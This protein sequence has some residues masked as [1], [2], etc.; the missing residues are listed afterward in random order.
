M[1]TLEH[2]QAATETTGDAA[3]KP[4]AL[5]AEFDNVDAVLAAARRAR[6]AGYNR[7]DV[8]SPF[9]IH[10]IDRVLGTPPTILP[11][12]VL[13][14]GLSG[15]FGALALTNYTMAYF[16]PF[17]ISGK[18]FLSQPAFVPIIFE[19]TILLAGITATV[20][21]LLLNK[22][23]LLANPLLKSERFRRFSSDRMF[24]VIEAKDRRFDVDQTRRFLEDQQPVAVELIHE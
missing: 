1:T 16:Y 7:V 8:H 5:I 3:S 10:G 12:L 15:L 19:C 22:L 18:P 2:Q 23:P 13:L 6:E 4:H 11:W 17:M 24:L 20:F 9:P 14:G 21:M